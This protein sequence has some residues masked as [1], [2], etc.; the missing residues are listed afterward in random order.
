MSAETL[1]DVLISP[2]FSAAERGAKQLETVIASAVMRLAGLGLKAGSGVLSVV[3]IT[4]DIAS[5]LDSL[6]GVSQRTGATAEGIRRIGFAVSQAGGSAEAARHS[7]ENL[8]GFIHHTPGAERFLHQMGVQTRTPEGQMREMSAIFTDTGQHLSRMP[9]EQAASSA[10]TLGMDEN[11]LRAMQRGVDQHSG[12]YT[13]MAQ[14]IGFNADNAAASA[15]RFMTSLRAFGEMSD[16]VRDKLGAELA[17][18]LSGPL[19]TLRQQILDNFPRI[20][21]TLTAI[22]RGLLWLG[23]VAGRVVYRLIQLAG[24]IRDGWRSLNKETRQVIEVSGLLV[25]AWQLVNRVFTMSPVGRI[26][27]LGTALLGL[28]DD[29]K[30]WQEG[31]KSIVDWEAWQ[32]EI[33]NAGSIIKTLDEALTDLFTSFARV[34]GIDPGTWSLKWDLGN[35]IGQMNE[36]SKMLSM[37]ADL[38]NALQAGEW[39][40]VKRLGIALWQQ[41][42]TP[43]PGA[44]DTGKTVVHTPAPTGDGAGTFNWVAPLVA[45]LEPNRWWGGNVQKYGMALLPE[46]ARHYIPLKA[47]NAPGA[48]TQIHQQNTWHIQGSNAR[49]I[50]QEIQQRQLDANARL[51]RASQPGVS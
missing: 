32:T 46:P 48:G 3:D 35:F 17:G 33:D 11:T 19:D 39:G 47:G 16:M 42:Q 8:A 34:A 25:A 14:A 24:D 20:E 40:E 7:L 51:L 31:G 2:G 22:V 26:I 36:L 18:G 13:A 1:N 27:M 38:L 50:G 37:I 29:Y 23:E 41:G 12:E 5:A 4:A 6:Y 43:V 49:D 21:G 28:Y 9:P 44:D 10:K 15:S 45:R 30:V